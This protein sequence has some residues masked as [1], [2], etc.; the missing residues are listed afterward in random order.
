MVCRRRWRLWTTVLLL[1]ALPAVTQAAG[2]GGAAAPTVQPTAKDF[3]A[4][5]A[6][7]LPGKVADVMRFAPSSITAKNLW[8]EGICGDF[9]KPDLGLNSKRPEVRLNSAILI[10][11]LK[12]LNT[13]KT[14]IN[15]LN[16]DDPAVRYWAARGLGDLSGS[17]KPVGGTTLSK[18]TDALDKQVKVEKVGVVTQELVKALVTYNASGALLDALEAV[19][20]QMQAGTPDVSLLQTAGMAL[21]EVQKS[22]ATAPAADKLRAA[23][24]TANLGSF[25]A[26]QQIAYKASLRT[27]DPTSTVPADYAKSTQKVLESAVGVCKAAGASSLSVKLAPGTSP[28]ELLMTAN[29]A[30][31]TQGKPGDLQKDMKTVATPPVIKGQ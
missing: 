26:Q 18:V 31:G 25:A 27:V 9:S 4:T 8:A 1:A 5:A 10:H 29:N 28:E 2:V 13:D 30:F 6:K 11:E 22:I 3:E 20:A 17:V 16:H 7:D 14:L 21:D 24:A 15:M 12:M 19:G 23:G